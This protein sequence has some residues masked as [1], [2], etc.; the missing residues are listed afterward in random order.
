MP[1]AGSIYQFRDDGPRTFSSLSFLLLPDRHQPPND[2]ILA[3]EL[4]LPAIHGL[5]LLGA[6]VAQ[7]V[8]RPV[9]VLG[10]H[11]LVEAPA[12]QAAARIAAGKVLVGPAG[13]VELAAVADVED[14]AA[15]GEVDGSAVLAVVGQERAR[16]EVAE[17]DGRA[18][19]GEGGRRGGSYGGVESVAEEEEEEDVEGGD[20]GVCVGGA[21]GGAARSVLS[22]GSRTNGKT[23]FG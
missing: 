2:Q 1:K 22:H 11:V 14:A 9:E 18:L 19:L 10:Q 8:E 4:L 15:H 21:R 3:L 7:G 20:E 23:R 12:G 17:D 16:G 13:A 5:H 6:Q